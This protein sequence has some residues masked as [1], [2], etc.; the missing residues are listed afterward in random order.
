MP[1]NRF[2]LRIAF[3]SGI[4]WQS[5]MGIGYGMNAFMQILQQFNNFFL[6]KHGIIYYF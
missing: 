2:Y 5:E 1:E 6:D 3:L 4:R